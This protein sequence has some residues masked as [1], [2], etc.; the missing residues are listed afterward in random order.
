M[1]LTFAAL[2]HLWVS[3]CSTPFWPQHKV[4]WKKNN[5]QIN[6]LR[7]FSLVASLILEYKYLISLDWWSGKINI[8]KMA[9]WLPR[10]W[11]PFSDHLSI[12]QTIDLIAWIDC[13]LF[14]LQV[15]CGSIFIFKI[16]SAWKIWLL[17]SWFC[18]QRHIPQC[19]LKN[20]Q[21]WFP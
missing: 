9:P 17:N 10:K 21:S 6:W 7:T 18:P 15:W 1:I 14:V 12:I 13:G 19:K 11:W 5:W 20:T 2:L 4:N 8:L 3:E 16:V